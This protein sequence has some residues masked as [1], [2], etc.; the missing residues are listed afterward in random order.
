MICTIFYSKMWYF[1]QKDRKLPCRSDELLPSTLLSIL[2]CSLIFFSYARRSTTYWHFEKWIIRTF[3]INIIRCQELATIVLSWKKCNTICY[4]NYWYANRFYYFYIENN[5]SVLSSPFF[6][7][8]CCFKSGKK[9]NVEK[10]TLTL[11]I[12]V[13]F[14]HSFVLNIKCDHILTIVVQ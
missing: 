2:I 13:F 1:F 7:F 10:L 5:L 11:L 12:Q 6:F 3:Q 8:C 14:T 4:C 9:N